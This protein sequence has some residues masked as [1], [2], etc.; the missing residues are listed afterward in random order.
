MLGL[1]IEQGIPGAAL[2]AAP[3]MFPL[4]C[5]AQRTP[6][7][8]LADLSL[9]ELGNLRVTTVALRDEHGFPAVIPSTAYAQLR[10]SF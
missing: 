1:S 10:Y 8:D 4:A 9:E 5:G 6:A 3:F 7:A 2:A